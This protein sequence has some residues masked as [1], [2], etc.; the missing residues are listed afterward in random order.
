[1]V[2]NLVVCLDCGLAE[3]TISNEELRLLAQSMAAASDGTEADHLVILGKLPSAPNGAQNW[4]ELYRA[5]LFESDKEKLQSR[6]D[7]A[8]R[9]L[10][11][12]ARELFKICGE[13]SE[14]GLVVDKALY[15]LRALRG[16]L[17]LKAGQPK[18]A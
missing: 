18:A 2:P 11:G 6:I 10:A 17:R 15:G 9:A 8:E 3:F 16:C 14:E 12:R 7:D 13:H 5:A 1:M 4:H